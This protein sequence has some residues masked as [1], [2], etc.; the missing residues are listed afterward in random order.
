MNVITYRCY[1]CK[2]PVSYESKYS[3]ETAASIIIVLTVMINVKSV[4]FS[5]IYLSINDVLLK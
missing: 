4:T 5:V 1:I 2:P 3:K